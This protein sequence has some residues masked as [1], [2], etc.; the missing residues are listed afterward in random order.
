MVWKSKEAGKECEE[1]G[2]DS[3]ENV[4]LVDDVEEGDDDGGGCHVLITS[5]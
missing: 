2:E 3:A 5:S 1:E 4:D